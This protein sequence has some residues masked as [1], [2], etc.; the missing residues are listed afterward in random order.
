MAKLRKGDRVRIGRNTGTIERV[1]GIAAWVSGSWGA[2][3][4]PLADMQKIAKSNAKGGKARAK[5]IKWIDNTARMGQYEAVLASGGVVVVRKIEPPN[6]YWF[7]YVVGRGTLYY[8]GPT[9]NSRKTVHK[10]TTAR[11]GKAAAGKYARSV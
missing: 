8:V 1:R 6:P 4:V 5:A 3:W 2:T 7:V 9:G 10:F 11:A